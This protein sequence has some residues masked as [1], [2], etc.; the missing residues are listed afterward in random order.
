MSP[1]VLTEGRDHLYPAA[2]RIARNTFFLAVADAANKGMVFFFYLIAAR[3]LGKQGFGVF[4]FGLSFTTMF[5]VLTDFG[6][7]LLAAREIARDHSK[8]FRLVNNGVIIRMISSL[9]VIGLIALL[10]NLLGY[11]PA[12]VRIVYICSVFV[13]ANG[14]LL[15]YANV[16][17]GFE[18][19]VYTAVGRLV[20]TII[21]IAGAAL[22]AGRQ[23]HPEYYALLY[24][25]AGLVAVGVMFATVSVK[26]VKPRLSFSPTESVGMLKTALPFGAA[27]ILASFYYW[28]GTTFL[29]KM[30]GDAAVGVYNAA[31]RLVMGL[32]FV[33]NAFSSAMY[34]A[35]ARAFVVDTKQLGRMTGRA[36]GYAACLAVPLGVVGTVLAGPMI[37]VL[38]GQ[39]YVESVLVLRALVWWG[40]FVCMNSILGSYF[41]AVNRPGVITVQTAVAL[42]VNLAGNIALIP[43]LG[44]LGA[45]ISIVL[46]EGVS[47]TF[48]LTRQLHPDSRIQAEETIRLLPKAILA[49]LATALAALVI[50]SRCQVLGLALAPV[51]Y[52][53]LLLLLGGV[54]RDDVN[55]LKASV[56]RKDG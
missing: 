43:L 55:M 4:S 15:F 25:G 30:Q 38:Y 50:A 21:M 47:F 16:F 23:P 2:T 19:N 8:A 40:A 20:Q 22:L 29:S 18:Q 13:L 52:L 6:V 28:N 45:A 12:T 42:G 27:I 34:P 10:V 48:L 41:Y 26:F 5:A 24:V 39:G 36:M 51:L 17:Q 53:G 49:A 7:G 31:F 33:A 3:H 35:L 37:L 14:L 56:H 1:A 11:P 9:V 44:A 46:A 54:N 32:V